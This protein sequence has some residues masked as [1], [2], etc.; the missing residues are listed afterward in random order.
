MLSVDYLWNRVNLVLSC[1]YKCVTSPSVVIP[2]WLVSQLLLDMAVLCVLG[3]T[4]LLKWRYLLRWRAAGLV[5]RSSAVGQTGVYLRSEPCD[6]R[7]K[8]T[9]RA[10]CLINRL[11]NSTV[12]KNIRRLGVK[13]RLF[14]LGSFSN[15]N[16]RLEYRC[17]R[18]GIVLITYFV[19][20]L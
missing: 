15:S 8:K 18:E 6:V 7:G 11:K 14:V 17:T 10:W 4:G 5:M 12:C 16:T 1:C 2:W 9:G 19:V 3:L 13:E 20:F